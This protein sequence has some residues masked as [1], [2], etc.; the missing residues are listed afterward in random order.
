MNDAVEAL[1]K[2]TESEI[3]VQS[4]TWDRTHDLLDRL[5]EERVSGFEALVD[6]RALEVEDEK[7]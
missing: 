5:K 4:G 7:V 2:L 3:E 6:W 1:E